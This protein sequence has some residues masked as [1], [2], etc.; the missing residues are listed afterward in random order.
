MRL[1]HGPSVNVAVALNDPQA[2]LSKNCNLHC[3]YAYTSNSLHNRR[4]ESPH[5]LGYRI[6]SRAGDKPRPATVSSTEP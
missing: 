6:K 5:T 3:F 1:S 4:L 2:P